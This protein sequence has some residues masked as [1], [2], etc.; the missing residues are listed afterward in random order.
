MKPA[1]LL[2]IA[3][4]AGGIAFA[5]AQQAHSPAKPAH[6]GA[7]PSGLAPLEALLFE[8]SS[9]P[10]TVSYTGTVVVVRIGSR[11]AEASVYRIEHRAPDQTRRVY[12]APSAPL[13]RFGSQ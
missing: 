11:S 5:S 9:A 4:V 12:S 2:A 13:R 1:S 7:Q 6:S 8:A 3:L 10:S